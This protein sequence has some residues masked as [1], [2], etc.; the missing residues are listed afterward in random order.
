MENFYKDYQ[1]QFDIGSPPQTLSFMIDTGSSWM[2]T[3]ADLC[4]QKSDPTRTCDPRR[5]HSDQSSTFKDTD[6]EI[7]IRYGSG[8]REGII[9]HD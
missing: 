9:V 5:F 4:S 1:A 6:K 2:W 8:P 7:V 3:F